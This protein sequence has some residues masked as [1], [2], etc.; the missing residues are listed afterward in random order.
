MKYSKIIQ[1]LMLQ[2]VL[3][4]QSCMEAPTG[5]ARRGSYSNLPSETPVE[6]SGSQQVDGL[7]R[8]EQRK[9]LVAIVLENLKEENLR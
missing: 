7:Q 4:L 8:Q 2:T 9:T 1:I 6:V 5:V 3:F